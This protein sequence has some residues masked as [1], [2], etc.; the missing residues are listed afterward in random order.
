MPMHLKP[1]V[2][3]FRSDQH[4]TGDVLEDHYN[5]T[6]RVVIAWGK[7]EAALEDLIWHFLDLS[8][9][10]GRMI[11]ARLDARPKLEM[12]NV[13]AKR[14][15]APRGAADLRKVLSLIG[16]L[17]ADRNF[18]VHGNWGTIFPE[19]VPAAM[20]LRPKTPPGTIMTE[21]FSPKSG[22]GKEICRSYRAVQ[23][24]FCPQFA[25]RSAPSRHRQPK[26]SLDVESP[27]PSRRIES[28]KNEGQR[29]HLRLPRPSPGVIL[30]I[31]G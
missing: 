25:T 22:I 31:G 30:Y 18:I 15:L 19:N 12:L 7:L 28:D 29:Y 8:D 10:D 26:P 27:S 14:Y 24:L 17:Q 23:A 6:G 16:E 5:S 1:P 21:T 20:S 3:E 11:T 2:K 9:D 13:L 4:F